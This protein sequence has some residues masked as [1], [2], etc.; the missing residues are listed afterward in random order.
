MT[1]HPNRR[2]CGALLTDLYQLSMAYG[3]W[4]AGLA[5]REAVFHLFF[6]KQPFGGGY[7]IACGL[8]DAIEYLRTFGFAEEELAYLGRL[9]GNDGAPLFS[10]EFLDYLRR[11]EWTWTVDAVPEGTVV[12][13]HEPLLR[14]TGPLIQCQL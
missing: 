6:R 9:T 4:K 2:Q 13:P 11:L 5:S 8:S 3:Y 10:P 12:F 7:S 14:V 1:T